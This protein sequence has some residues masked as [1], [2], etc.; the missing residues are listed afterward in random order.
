VTVRLVSPSLSAPGEDALGDLC[1]RARRGD[2]VAQGLLYRRFVKDVAR[3]VHQLTGND[4]DLDDLVQ[5]TFI[6]AFRKLGELRDPARLRSWLAS[7]ATN[8]C[9][10]RFKLTAKRGA[11]LRVLGT[12]EPQRS[13]PRGLGELQAL[14]EQLA[15]L[16]PSLREPWVLRRLC[17]EDLL[18]VAEMCDASLATVKRRIAEADE[19]LERRLADD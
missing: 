8:Q 16:D 4:R 1:A 6:I 18:V 7:I 5:E 3:W 2:R 10:Q 14:Y 12:S 17:D 9:R 11:V 19:W 13:D 15:Q